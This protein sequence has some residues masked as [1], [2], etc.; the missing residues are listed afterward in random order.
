MNKLNTKALYSLLI[1]SLGLLYAGCK[2]NKQVE[3]KRYSTYNELPDPN[4]DTTVAWT[5][6]DNQLQV[7]FVSIDQKFEKSVEPQIKTKEN[8]IKLTGW[9]GERLSAQLLLWGKEETKDVQITLSDFSSKNNTLPSSI[10][11]VRFVRYVMTDEFA[12]GCGHRKP[13]NY[14]AE[15]AADVLDNVNCMNIE[16]STV[17]PVWV[18][19]AIPRE[20]PAGN[21]LA[22]LHVLTQDKLY[23]ELTIELEIQNETLPEPKEWSFHLDLWQHP[24]A[25]ARVE[26]VELWSE[27]H[28]N[29]L[30]PAMK[31]LA[32]AG[33]KVIT[34]TLN[35]DP[36]NHQCYDAY[37]DMIIWTKLKDG[38]WEYDYTIFDKWVS[39]MMDLGIDKMINCYSVV[40]WNNELRYKDAESG[41]F[42][43]I[44][45]NPG[46]DI[47]N[48]IWHHF[49]V[50]FKKHLTEKGWLE[51]TN[52]A[53]DER[54]PE[55]MAATI[56]MLQ[57]EAPEL[58]ISYADN[59]KS[60][61]KYPFV[62]DIS[63]KVDASFD[64][65][66]I[67]DRRERGLVTTFYVCCADPFPNMFTF[68]EPAESVYA[69]WY[70]LASG[71]DGFLRWAYN[72]WVENPLLDSRFITWPAG[73]TYMIYP[74]ARSS[75]RFERLIEGIQDVEKIKVLQKRLAN[76]PDE[77]AAT[78]LEK[79]NTTLSLFSTVDPSEDYIHL[80]HKGKTVINDITRDLN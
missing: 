73:D 39:F 10:A 52:I 59:Q 38:S 6:K 71:L 14:N 48:E 4:R 45:A 80:I 36:W 5:S 66:D 26:N 3:T 49:F 44:Q 76:S 13:E 70:A 24:S 22:T 54:T 62:K 46:T 43:D 78:L 35:K 69:G 68:S 72:S 29:A 15:L 60:Y 40:P 18:S 12:E 77:H 51:I 56:D 28:F 25:V 30:K 19:V 67:L 61:K 74:G 7:S 58:G 27:E 57:R 37:E 65:K 64:L 20:V 9:Q 34:T 8:R 42:I 17:R 41:T 50:D 32:D 11:E 33:Q 63:I 75:I 1:L 53:M 31:M 47:F 16:A 21:Y 79:L 55:E 23:E 2:P